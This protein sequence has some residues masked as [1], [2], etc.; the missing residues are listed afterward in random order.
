MVG[1][2]DRRHRGTDQNLSVAVN[3]ARRL[4]ID[5]LTDAPQARRLSA[6]AEHV[7]SLAH[8]R[9]PPTPA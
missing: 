5:G 4:E 3:D 2:Y 7:K 6:C 8:A 1:T 9:G